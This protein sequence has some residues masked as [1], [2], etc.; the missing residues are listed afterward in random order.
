M[1]EEGNG[2]GSVP[3]R[4][5]VPWVKGGCSGLR[6]QRGGDLGAGVEQ[7][8]E[9]AEELLKLIEEMSNVGGE[10]RGMSTSVCTMVVWHANIL[11]TSPSGLG[12]CWL[13]KPP[14]TGGTTA[15]SV[16]FS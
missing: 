16:T 7:L 6:W 4:I 14:T 5:D 2:R 13:L 10:G 3:S 15:L 11:L 1:V 12:L 9:K 8:T